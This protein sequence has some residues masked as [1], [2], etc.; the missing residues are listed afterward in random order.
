MIKVP[1]FFASK[2]SG[3]STSNSKLARK[4]PVVV[5]RS[6][7]PS[8][9][10]IRPDKESVNTFPSA[11][12][13]PDFQEIKRENM[14]SQE[15]ENVTNLESPKLTDLGERNQLAD[16]FE[17]AIEDI[18]KEIRNFDLDTSNVAVN[19]AC[20]GK[21]NVTESPSVQVSNEIFSQ[22]R[23]QLNH[24]LPRAPLAVISNNQNRLVHAE[25][26]WKRVARTEIGIDIVMVEVVGEKRVARETEGVLELPKK[27]KVS[28]AGKTKKQILAKAG[29][30]PCQKQ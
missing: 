3:A 12:T 8:P 30:Q 13:A 5:V 1:S 9:E 24:S 18:D 22:A 28:Q 21:E 4:P 20:P 7:K 26:L 16:D 11:N 15:S 14:V 27:R 23:A 19:K 29:I 10:V 17:E 2:K 25:G 6:G